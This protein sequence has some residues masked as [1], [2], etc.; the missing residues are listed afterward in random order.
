MYTLPKK[1]KLFAIAFMVVGAIGMI[2]GFLSAPKTTAEVKEMM[3]S[4]HGDGHGETVE[5]VSHSDSHGEVNE[6]AHGGEEAHYEHVLH[7]MQNRPWSALYIASFFFFMIALGTLAFYAIQYAAQAGWSPVLFRVMEGITAYLPVASVIIF[8]LLLLSAFHVNHIFHWMDPELVNPE[9]EHYD[10]LIAGKS[11]F[12]N[13]PFFLIRAA[14]F[15]LGWNL[16]RWISRKN[17]IADDTAEDNRYFKK[18]FKA[19]AGFLVFFIVTESM[20]S[21]DWIMSF[22]PHWFSTLFGWYVFAGMMV[23]AIT[24]IAMVTIYLKSQGYLEHVN[25]SHIHDLAKFMFGFSIFWT[26]LWFS[27]FM[28][29][30][31][32]NIPEEVTYFVTRI[33]DYNLPFFGMLA[34]NFIFPVL[35]LMNSDYKRVNWFVIMTGIVILAGHYIDVFNMVMPATVGTSWYIGIPEIGSLLFFFGLFVLVVFTALT[36]APLLAKRN[37]FIKESKHFHY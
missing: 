27:Q 26:Y 1:L 30:W 24:V 8:V 5:D 32:A 14:I 28:L 3:A 20:M 10:K 29:I 17:S 2:A 7:Q 33:E 25:D 18:N 16:Y 4:H 34:M 23:S 19:S 13:V 35:L 11:G 22:D 21:W 36:K 12:L 9:S 31:Y 6:D 37:P 15:L